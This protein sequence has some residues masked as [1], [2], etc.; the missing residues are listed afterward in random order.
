VALLR[1]PAA[2]R[3]ALGAR[4]RA[5]VAEHF[6]L[7]ATASAYARLHASLLPAGAAPGSAPPAW[8]GG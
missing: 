4:A 2:G 6:S 1:M 5:R 7:A 3:R 8:Q